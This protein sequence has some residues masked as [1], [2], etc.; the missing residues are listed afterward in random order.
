[1]P[2]KEDSSSGS[3]VPSVALYTFAY[4]RSS[5][6]ASNADLFAFAHQASQVS[7]LL[8]PNSLTHVV[9]RQLVF[10]AECI[11]GQKGEKKKIYIILIIFIIVYT[12]IVIYTIM[13]IINLLLTQI[14]H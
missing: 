10:S 1:M 12:Y 11:D 4:T 3:A 14:G 6:A 2:L 9:S 5:N 7:F 8:S 13:Y